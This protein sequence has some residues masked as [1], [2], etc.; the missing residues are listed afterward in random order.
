MILV[1]GDGRH[2]I[3]HRVETAPVDV[4]H[5]AQLFLEQPD[6]R[7]TG[8][9]GLRGGFIRADHRNEP[10]FLGHGHV[11]QFVQTAEC[12]DIFARGMAHAKMPVEAG[13]ANDHAAPLN[14]AKVIRRHY[15]AKLGEVRTGIFFDFWWLCNKQNTAFAGGCGA[16]TRWGFV[17]NYKPRFRLWCGWRC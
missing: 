15:H 17:K 9:L 16:K 2:F 1:R 5:I 10:C 6:Q 11:P 7:K 4:Q 3:V 8:A 13:V 12:A 14:T